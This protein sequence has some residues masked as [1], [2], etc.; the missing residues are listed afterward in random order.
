M[1]RTVVLLNPTRQ[2]FQQFLGLVQL[3]PSLFFEVLTFLFAGILL[4]LL[5]LFLVELSASV[6]GTDHALKVVMAVLFVEGYGC[7]ALLLLVLVV[8]AVGFAVLH[9]QL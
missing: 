1:Q 2:L 4:F 7:V 8:F 6:F 3:L 5:Y 9:H